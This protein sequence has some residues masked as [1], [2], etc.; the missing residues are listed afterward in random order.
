[1]YQNNLYLPHPNFPV[2]SAS[3]VFA[4][5]DA[6]FAQAPGNFQREHRLDFNLSYC[7]LY[8]RGSQQDYR[9]QWRLLWC[10]HRDHVAIAH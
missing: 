7:Y 6:H 2:D 4:R 1:M 8:F 5:K 10:E 3:S 9:H